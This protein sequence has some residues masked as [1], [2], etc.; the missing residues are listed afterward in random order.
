[1]DAMPIL[2]PMLGVIR[3]DRWPVLDSFMNNNVTKNNSEWQQYE[4][5]ELYNYD[6]SPQLNISK[7]DVNITCKYDIPKEF[8]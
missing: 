7:A 5:G 3:T 2:E 1:M 4:G 8:G 6:C